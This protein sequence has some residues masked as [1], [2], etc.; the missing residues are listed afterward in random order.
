[1]AKGGYDYTLR[2]NVDRTAVNSAVQ[3]IDS[4]F[5]QQRTLNINTQQMVNQITTALNGIR[6]NTSQWFQGLP[7]GNTGRGNNV[8]NLA[9]SLYTTSSMASNNAN[10]NILSGQSASKIG[11][12]INQ[13][14][15]LQTLMSDLQ[16]NRNNFEA[17]YGNNA[18]INRES[19]EYLDALTRAKELQKEFDT[20]TRSLKSNRYDTTN[21]NG[22]WNPNANLSNIVDGYQRIREL[23][24]SIRRSNSGDTIDFGMVSDNFQKLSYTVTN[25]NGDVRSFVATIDTANGGFRV[26]E[27]YAD[28]TT[29]SLDNV[30][31]S[32]NSVIG[33]Y[34]S[35]ILTFRQLINT[36]KQGMNVVK[37]FDA[38]LTSISL[39]MD[40]TDTQLD[41]LGDAV[42][43]NAKKM[44][45]S[46][47][48]AMDVSKIYA[49]MQSSTEEIIELTTPTIELSNASGLDTS[50]TSNYIQSV[51]QQFEM[52][53]DE[54]EHVADVYESISANIRL[55]FAEGIGSI[56]E[57]VQVA[58]NVANDAGLSFEKFAAIIAKT[59]ETTR[60]NGSTIGN[61][62]K[63]ILTRISKAS[64]VSD[65]IDPETLSNAAESLSKVGIEVY[66][67]Q[68]EFRNVD[69]IL[70]ELSEKYDSLS[71][72]MQ[73]EISY[74][75]AAT[76]NTNTLSVALKNY[77]EITELATEATEADGLAKE[78]Q[79][80]YMESYTAK[81]A[82]A[83][84]QIDDLYQ[85]FLDNDLTK[86]SIDVFNTVL[87]VINEI[88]DKTGAFGEI[89]AIYFGG[90]GVLSLANIF[91]ID[92]IN[93][94]TTGIS[95]LLSSV[96]SIGVAMDAASAAGGGFRGVL[97]GI[98]SLATQHPIITS[99]AVAITAVAAAYSILSQHDEKL[100]EAGTEAQKNI[101]SLYNDLGDTRSQIK[102]LG[103]EVSDSADS[104]N[105]T[106]DAIEA[107]AKKY[108]ELSEGV[109]KLSNKNKSLTTDEYEQYLDISNQLAEQYPTLISGADAEGNAMLN[110]STNVKTAA[111]S[112]RDLYDAQQLA[113]NVDIGK[114]LQSVYDG[115]TTQIKQYEKELTSL[116]SSNT[117][118]D[119][120]LEEIDNKYDELKNG[121]FN[122]GDSFI[123]FN[124]NEFDYIKELLAD[125]DIDTLGL[126]DNQNGYFTIIDSKI[127][128]LTKEQVASLND[129]WAE[130]V[131][132]ELDAQKGI[133]NT[134]KLVNSQTVKSNELLIQDQWKSLSSSISQYLETAD[135]FTGLSSTIQSAI[136]SNLSN[137]DTS[138]I[139]SEYGGE[140]LPFIYAEYIEPLSSLKPEF[141]E[142]LASLLE[143]DS[144]TISISEYRNQWNDT[145]NKIFADEETRNKWKDKLGYTDIIE[146]ALDKS[147]YLSRKY[148]DNISEISSMSIG[149]REIAYDI[150]ANDGFT[151]TFEQLEALIQKAKE[152][153]SEGFD[154]NANPIFDG[155]EE[156]IDSD[157]A[158]FD[159][160]KAVGYLKKAKELYD[161]GLVGTDDFKQI[162]SYL[163]PSG[164]TDADN[165]EE[166][167]E[168]ASRYLTEDDSGVKAFLND[169]EAKDLAEYNEETQAWTYSIEDLTQ[170]ANDMGMGFEFFMDMFGR[171]ED[172]GARNNF[173]GST[174]DGINHLTDLYGDLA[175]AETELSLLEQNSPDNTTAI[176]AKKNEIEALN[177]SIDETIENMEILLTQGAEDANTKVTAGKTAIGSML[178]ELTSLDTSSSNYDSIKGI[179]YDQIQ[180][181]ADEY[182]IELVWENGNIVGIA[183]SSTE[184]AQEEANNN[185]VEI[186]YTQKPI[187]ITNSELESND[188]ITYEARIDTYQLEQDIED[189]VSGEAKLPIVIS[190]E[191]IQQQI[192]EMTLSEKELPLYVDPD[193][194]IA[195]FYNAA[196]G[197]INPIPIE[198]DSSSLKSEAD[199][200]KA[201]VDGLSGTEKIDGDVSSA[202][203]KADAAASYIDSLRPILN[204]GADAS[205][206]TSAI[207]SALSG[208]HTITVNAQVS[209]LPAAQALGTA[210]S[211]G[212][213]LDLWNSYRNSIGAYAYGN[214]WTLHNNESALVNELGVESIVRDGKWFTIPGG[215][216]IEQLKRGDII[217]NADQTKELIKNGRVLSGGGHGKLAMATG[218][219]Y[220]MLNAYAGVGS[221]G[222]TFK[223]GSSS[224]SSSTSSSSSSSSSSVA[225][226]AKALTKTAKSLADWAADLFDWIEIKL[227]ALEKK[228]SSY[229]DKAQLYI[230]KGLDSANNYKNAEKNLQ[231]AINTVNSQ[232][233]AN[234]QGE[235]RYSL[236]AEAAYQQALKKL[237][238]KN[239]KTFKSAVS[240]I[241]SGGTIDISSYNEKVREAI[242]EFQKWYDKSQDCKSAIDEL[243][244]TLNDYSKELYELPLDQASEKIDKL[245]A[246]MDVL[247]SKMDVA[248]SGGSSINNFADVLDENVVSA[249]S[250]VEAAAKDITSK[251]TAANKAKASYDSAVEKENETE[252]ALKSAT[253]TVKKYGSK[254]GSARLKKI[255]NGETIST[256]GLKGKA[257]AAAK[258]YNKAVSANEVAETATAS[259][260]T[261]Y[262][263][264]TTALNNAKTAKAQIDAYYNTLKKQQEEISKYEGKASYEYANYLAT[265]ELNNTASQ[266]Q[267][268][269]TALSKAEANLTSA[270]NTQKST[271]NAVTSKANS[272]LSSKYA[273]K[274]TTAQ[275]NALKAGTTVST[276]GVTNKTLLKYLNDYNSKVQAATSASTA[277]TN[278]QNALTTA[279]QNATTS[280]AELAAARSEYAKETFENIQNYYSELSSYRN[281]LA[282][283]YSSD[284]EL[285]EAYG[286][287][288]TTADFQNEIN[289][290]QSQRSALVEEQSKLEAQLKSLVAQGYV[291]ENTEE[292]YQ[293]KAQIIE[294]GN[295]IDSIDKEVLDL[296]D[297]MRE[298]VFYQQ[299]NKAL[300]TA[301]KLRKS[302]SSIKDIISDEMMFDDDGRLTDFG[303]TSLA[304][305]IKEYESDLNS[306]STL[307]K[308]RNQYI[309]DYNSGKNSTNYSQ[310]EFEEDMDAIT[311]EIQNM[312][313][314]TNSVRESIIQTI[315]KQ[316][317]A[318]LNAVNKV[319]DA[320]EELLQKQKD[321]YDYDKSLKSKTNDIQLLE[322]Q[323]RALDGMTDAESRAQKARLEAE[324]QE[325]QDELDETV[326]DHLYD[327]QIQGL[328]DLKVELQ[329]NYDNYVNELNSNLDTIVSAVGDATKLISGSLNTVNTTVQK[330]LNSYGVSGLTLESL[331]VKSFASGTTRVGYKGF[332][333]T[334][335]NGREIVLRD[336]S[337]LIPVNTSDGIIPS[338]L[339]E[340]L[341][342]MAQNYS[343][344]IP[345]PN[346]NI[347]DVS[348]G[349]GTTVAPIVNCDVSISG[350]NIDE[351]GVIRAINKQ[352]P[353]ISKTIQNDIRKDLKK[354]GR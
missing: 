82:T 324:R 204:I 279:Q 108:S 268:N 332:A 341:I 10:Y 144:S 100:I 251:Q 38:G 239:D 184:T 121:L 256:K 120:Q 143:I 166:N 153:T 139:T 351:D 297:T 216:H 273:S 298:E 242:E 34:L 270:S 223:G 296:Q 70:T 237:N 158:G 346:L 301:E 74:N 19:Q 126:T 354:S 162:A 106:E 288:L 7:N 281:S 107:I 46:I 172:Y 342:D 353:V 282:E 90:R 252:A 328:D 152:E 221:G 347:A 94:L 17:T 43:D 335:E 261:A 163:S 16:D 114:N 76:R 205:S 168:K 259:A 247:N 253:K 142:E 93:N 48:E 83:K 53:S 123:T 188:T 194:A 302:L 174:E 294:V 58:G 306:L 45:T 40:L 321:Y 234:R 33:N 159:Y 257:L 151:G 182:H 336:G 289:A 81:L 136:L 215:A 330:L 226:A 146:D 271:A 307:L 295:E 24:D 309:S 72:A 63:T 92:R 308:K 86:G 80:K 284:R 118:I 350:N 124:S 313:K 125:Y 318:E 218:T 183:E 236:Q 167:Y 113:A 29:D 244:A 154:I 35:N 51:L 275:K 325:L 62:W 246:A 175:E 155:I 265:Q 199:S 79:E 235:A 231:N 57:G 85:A 211:N 248:T 173:I 102:N 195:D 180:A 26:L 112:I 329:E 314:D 65:D 225:S 61:S 137:A 277:L 41:D 52:T 349:M 264:A 331:G 133:L 305:D 214:D 89:A 230:E 13:L 323:I 266:H 339:T 117:W 191:E 15:R 5:S 207:N 255:A 285:K 119:S 224:T 219:A 75:L 291:K 22:V 110:L 77:A 233:D 3:S 280:A 196:D 128:E 28:Q 311:E 171:L 352:L 250:S 287:D 60:Q 209:G 39:T 217:F 104:I 181:I 134:D 340:R 315:V 132:S 210:H 21:N 229:Y 337:V 201:Y 274:L 138:L 200:G 208:S 141:Q 25:T 156:A 129:K 44:G 192:D 185:P 88:M 98:L 101:K 222:I 269:L 267:E 149:D 304:M 37:E 67:S 344:D 55:D 105:N 23:Q 127:A 245:S 95:G 30:S 49:N 258:A 293:M 27:T 322:Q 109:D 59:A 178:E 312:L 212:T 290:L 286:K 84:D 71:D 179:I 161:D 47:S 157:N 187:D 54:A 317:E 243:N 240:T 6:I 64:N 263:N 8:N 189:I 276:S 249:Q 103:K 73:S 32:L 56:A 78:N 148:S 176:E 316:G 348:S 140:V 69:L 283:Q 99:L 165:F 36:I 320:R 228:A 272:I 334:Q 232:I 203:S 164:A 310:K 241:K 254:L 198:G 96:N 319:I 131:G 193:G 130:H 327:L 262:T 190:Q 150:V 50:T 147:Q 18:N 220:G 14:T 299:L 278:A 68:G 333:R 260:K 12:Y 186:S 227:D 238:S 97:A 202:K 115:I 2:I 343:V 122:E 4:I 170:A 300:E 87:N 116:A 169:L 206:V 338:D 213:V 20:L 42:I 303:I 11:T 66:N 145:L 91:G 197:L 160:E 111:D 9:N 31:N 345:S 326:N 292:W 1:M 135:S 177:Q